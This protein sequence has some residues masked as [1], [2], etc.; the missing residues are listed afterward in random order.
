VKEMTI[1]SFYFLLRFNARFLCVLLQT[2]QPELEL[3]D[4]GEDLPSENRTSRSGRAPER[5]TTVARRIL[6]AIRQYSIWLVSRAPIIT[7][8]AKNHPSSVYIQEMLRVYASVLTKLIHVFPVQELPVVGYLLE[9]DE[10]TV[11]FKPF[12][13][14]SLPANCNFY[15]GQNGLPKPRSTDRGVERSHPNVEMKSRIRNLFVCALVNHREHDFPAV[16]NADTLEFTF[17]GDSPQTSSFTN[18]DFTPSTS[19]NSERAKG[20]LKTPVSATNS[21]QGLAQ[22]KST[23]VSDSHQSMDTNMQRM[24]SSLYEPSSRAPS[25]SNETSYGMHTRTA[26]EVFAP[27]NRNGYQPARISTQGVIASLPGITNSPFAPQP[28][29]LGHHSPQY[30]TAYMGRNISPMHLANSS[31]QGAMASYHSSAWGTSASRQPNSSA[32]ERVAAELQDSLTRQFKPMSISSSGFSSSSSIYAGTQQCDP[33]ARGGAWGRP[34]F[35][36]T[37]DDTTRYTGTSSFDRNAMLQSSILDNNQ[38]TWADIGQTPPGGQ[39]G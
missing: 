26:N 7:A 34:P 20:R 17:A 18:T 2:I 28:N 38:S 37:T 13:D 29:E 6:P 12:R 32:S 39:R 24:V 16:F 36:A 35:A 15:I 22:S 9:E 5:I 25:A 30:E 23:G 33:S 27:I 11:G 19:T 1:E 14:P 10:A 4:A 31:P 8:T 21:S 3:D